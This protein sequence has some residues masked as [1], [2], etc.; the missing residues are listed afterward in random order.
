MVITGRQPDWIPVAWP[1][2]GL[3]HDKNA[4]VAIAQQ[5]AD[6]GVN[7]LDERA[8]FPDGT[9]SVEAGIYQLLNLMTTG[10]FF[11]FSHLSEWFDE[12]RMYHRDKGK[13][14]KLLDDLMSATRYAYMMERHA[15]AE[16]YEE[17]EEDYSSQ[18]TNSLGY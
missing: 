18:E 8:T 14:V 16:P 11:V 12:F 3:Q 4:G 6:E 17:W 5:Y 7:M 2:D 1:H 15:E 13:I 10:R 9:N